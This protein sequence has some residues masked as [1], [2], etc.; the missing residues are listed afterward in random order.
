VSLGIGSNV[1]IGVCLFADFLCLASYLSTKL[2]I[3]YFL[4]EKVYLI[5]S[6]RKP[7]LKDKLY[8][9]HAFGLVVFYVILTIL[10]FVFRIG[11][12]S[13][14]G[15]CFNGIQADVLAPLLVFDT[16]CNIYLMIMF[17]I[18]LR[19]L[20][21][22]SNPNSMS[23]QIA[24]RTLIGTS[25]TLASSVFN[26]MQ[27][28]IVQGERSWLCLI[29]CNLDILL[30][31][32]VVQ[33]ITAKDGA[34]SGSEN[35]STTDN[36]TKRANDRAL[37]RPEK[38]IMMPIKAKRKDTDF[39]DDFSDLEGGIEL[40]NVRQNVDGKG[41][42]DGNF[43]SPR[44]KS[45]GPFKLDVIK[46]NSFNTLAVQRRDGPSTSG[47]SSI[48]REKDSSDSMSLAALQRLDSADSGTRFI[49]KREGS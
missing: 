34:D 11:Y 35:K 44:S 31:V 48:M 22:Y 28:I 18:P 20:M 32:L 33:W 25:I 39:S 24:I 46:V 3:Y 5:R 7:R 21:S 6:V 42:V 36:D 41:G 16:G 19:Q 14:Q 27:L 13:E 10:Q 12:I 30:S 2:G 1:S 43:D 45:G 4:V 9:F 26:I 23:R 37:L 49:D 8:I 40:D 29:T 17:I 38:P 15:Q 47:G